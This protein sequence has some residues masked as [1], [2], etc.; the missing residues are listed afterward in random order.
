MKWFLLLLIFSAC[1]ARKS[2]RQP[3]SE[4]DFIYVYK[5]QYWTKQR[6]IETFGHKPSEDSLL[7]NRPDFR[8]WD[9]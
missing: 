2:P 4:E 6:F 3:H 8:L 1:V 9:K 7:R 5:N